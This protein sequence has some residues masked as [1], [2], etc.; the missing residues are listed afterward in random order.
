MPVVPLTQL[1]SRAREGRYAVGY[2][3]SWDV[4]SMEATLAAAEAERSPVILGI[5]GLSANHDWLRR[6]GIDVYGAVCRR[7]AER[8]TVPCSVLFNEADSRVE[9]ELALGTGYN[10]VMMH[11][12]GW[13]WDRLLADTAALTEAAHAVG[14][15]V[16]GEVGA[17]A[18]MGDRGEINDGIAAMTSVGEAQE[19]VGKTGVDC[20]AV[21]VGNVHFVTSDYHPVL[22]LDRLAELAAAVDVP[23]VLHGGSGTSGEA[24]RAAVAA[25]ITKVN[26]GTRLKHVFGTELAAR[27]AEDRL[28]P[29]LS[30]G[31]REAGD[32][33]V[34]AG[35]ALAELVGE[36]MT[37]LGSSGKA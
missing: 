4:Y 22:D 10:A 16:E 36:L 37:V 3:E 24:L 15:A 6:T 31:S 7:L 18:E 35:A 29:N 27:L 30:I 9:A 11:T 17:L 13:A 26:F 8:A 21:A 33:C 25:G 23:L 5:G 20:L 34:A 2:F 12:Q 19:F 1:L 32:V 28:E 14:T